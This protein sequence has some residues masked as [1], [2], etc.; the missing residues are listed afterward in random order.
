MAPVNGKPFLHYIFKYLEQQGCTRVVLSLGYKHE[1]ITDW[2]GEQQLSI[3][4]DHVIEEEPLG[5]GGGIALAMVKAKAEA[6][7]V[8][9]GDTLFQV[10]LAR[11]VEFHKDCGAE[12][13]LALKEMFRFNRYGSVQVD[14]NDTIVA[15]EEKGYKEAGYIN[16]GVYCVNRQR[17]FSRELPMKFSFEKEYLE[18][19][20]DQKCFLGRVNKDY[21]IDIGVPEDYERAQEDFKQL[22]P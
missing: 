11:L 7:I 15:F 19:Y 8:L 22:F 5:T 20:V 16:G 17:F 4:T 14:E 2:L 12:T 9:N 3:E 10:D 13:S 1:V 6:V 18:R 21:F